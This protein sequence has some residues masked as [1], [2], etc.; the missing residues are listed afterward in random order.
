MGVTIDSGWALR[1]FKGLQSC[2]DMAFV[3][4]GQGLQLFVIVDALGHGPDAQVSALRAK[5]L[6]KQKVEAPLQELFTACDKC[7]YGLRGA[8]MSAVRR[9]GELASY[10][11][12][13]NVEIYGP[14]GVTRPPPI[15]GTLGKGVTHFREFPIVLVPGQRWVLASD[16]LRTRDMAKSLA[17]VAQAAPSDA[18]TR[19]LELAGRDDDDVS[20]IVMDVR[21]AP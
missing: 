19:L 2:G 17:A 4:A 11:G 9:V 18:A 15:A 13:G 3:G 1:P 12:V 8:V 21:E 5:E 7:L 16:G 14:P 10:A 20:V 6:I